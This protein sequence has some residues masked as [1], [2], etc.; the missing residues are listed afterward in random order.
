MTREEA[1]AE[2]EALGVGLA[3][4]EYHGGHDEGYEG[5]SQVFSTVEADQS[6]D[7]TDEVS[8]SQEL[9]DALVEPVY[10]QLGTVWYDGADDQQGTVEWRV[11]EGLVVMHHSRLEWR[12]DDPREV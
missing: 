7:V 1:F 11:P 6:Q 8:L 4:V 9:E 10:E 5:V 3:V 12:S 2:L